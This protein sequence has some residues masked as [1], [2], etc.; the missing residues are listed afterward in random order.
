MG[1]LKQKQSVHDEYVSVSLSYTFSN[2]ENTAIEQVTD[3]V[4]EN[5]KQAA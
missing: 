2:K 3:T 4:N 5:T 1:N